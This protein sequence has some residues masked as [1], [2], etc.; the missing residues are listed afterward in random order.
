METWIIFFSLGSGFL[1]AYLS[2]LNKRLIKYNKYLTNGGLLILLFSMGS[3]IGVNDKVLSEISQIGFKAVLFALSSIM[4]SVFLV[5]I[6]SQKKSKNYDTNQ[7]TSRD[8]GG[9]KVN[10]KDTIIIAFTVIAG[11]ITGLLFL[12]SVH[13]SLINTISSY[14]LILL[15]FGVGIDIGLNKEMLKNLIKYGWNIIIIPILIAIGSILG[16]VIAGFVIGFSFNESAAVGAGFGWYSLS[17]IILS[18]L[19][20][21]ELGSIAFLTN[22]FREF[23]TFL[24]LPFVVKKF[25][26]SAG[27][28]PGGATT[29]DVTLPLIK[30]VA[31]EEMVIPAL[32]SGMV[33]T[34]LVPILV[35][36]LIKL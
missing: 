29:M 4:G 18:Q 17:G 35:P 12:N 23:L 9:E 22:I 3:K 13:I 31:G 19:H 28:A 8:K 25:G 15:L 33:L 32:V 34:T 5:Y 24:I 30:K 21:V 2:L 20:S 6:F 1:I 10:Y 7:F 27:I 14:A 11:L 16:T 26:N 36:F